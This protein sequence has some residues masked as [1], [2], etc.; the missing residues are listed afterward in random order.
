M[1]PVRFD[2]IPDSA[3]NSN[4]PT[5]PHFDLRLNDRFFEEIRQKISATAVE[6]LSERSDREKGILA[7]QASP[8]IKEDT[9]AAPLPPVV[10]SPDASSHIAQ[11]DLPEHAVHVAPA[12][13]SARDPYD[14][15]NICNAVDDSESQ[16]DAEEDFEKDPDEVGTAVSPLAAEPSEVSSLATATED[17]QEEEEEETSV[18]DRYLAT[19]ADEE[20]LYTHTADSSVVT[21]LSDGIFKVNFRRVAIERVDHVQC[22]FLPLIA[23]MR[24]S[25]T[26][27]R[28][29]HMKIVNAR[30]YST[31]D[32]ILK[33]FIRI[34][35]TPLCSRS[36]RYRF[37]SFCISAPE[38][39][40]SVFATIC[41]TL[42]K[43]SLQ[44]LVIKKGMP[45][46]TSHLLC[47]FSVDESF[48]SASEDTA[49]ILIDAIKKMHNLTSLV[50]E[51]TTLAVDCGLR[52]M[53][54][55]AN[56]TNIRTIHLWSGIDEIRSTLSSSSSA[57]TSAKLREIISARVAFK[58][59]VDLRN[60]ELRRRSPR[61]RM[62][63]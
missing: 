11:R 1:P 29:I 61:F 63:S 56:H 62:S 15:K 10:H 26:R 47:K 7:S 23:N 20:N 16:K 35:L 9:L 21:Y 53:K 42:K 22:V 51:N 46:V 43:S 41:A 50:F 36:S 44:E 18:W 30:F 28:R 58:K 5:S 13:D 45:C 37:G 24:E 4:L 55:A 49:G 39:S 52:I 59:R 25:R 48:E 17:D 60:Q 14:I 19:S 34:V 6:L 54:A 40:S 2:C 8:A 3:A 31:E 57:E 38:F 32:E 33:D 27:N 12:S